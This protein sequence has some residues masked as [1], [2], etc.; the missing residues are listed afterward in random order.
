MTQSSALPLRP[1][2]TQILNAID[3]YDHS[4]LAQDAALEELAETVG[5]SIKKL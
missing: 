2:T 4:T 1:S 5:W 3:E